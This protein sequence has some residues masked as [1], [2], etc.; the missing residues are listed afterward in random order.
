[1]TGRER[2]L[3][4]LAAFGAFWFASVPVGLLLLVAQSEE[5][6]FA[7]I[8]AVGAVVGLIFASTAGLVAYLVIKT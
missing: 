3:V 8:G 5:V 1:M 2:W 6:N 7:I 4:F